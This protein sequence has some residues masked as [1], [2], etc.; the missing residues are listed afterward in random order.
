MT[1]PSAPALAPRK[2]TEGWV[3]P[4]TKDAPGD[5][6]QS[7]L[8]EIG[9]VA[10][11][12]DGDEKR[13]AREIE[14]GR[15]LQNIANQWA[16]DR[17]RQPTGREV[18]FGLL[19]QLRGQRRALRAVTEHLNINTHPLSK[20]VINKRLRLALDGEPDRLLIKHLTSSL[21]CNEPE[22][23]QCSVR[24]SVLTHILT[25]ELL[26]HA[27]QTSDG[28]KQP[29]QPRGQAAD[30]LGLRAHFDGLE[31]TG[32]RGQK[33]LTE[34]NLRLVVSI[35]RKYSR[36]GM[37]LSDLIQEGN[38][39]LMRAVDRFDYRRGYK[40]ST[41]GHWWIR[42]AITRA[43][44]DKARAIRM[45]VHMVETLRK[46]T[47]AQEKLVDELGREPSSEDIALE[48]DVSP[49]RVRQITQVSREPL[50]LEAP[51]GEDDAHIGD[52]VQDQAASTSD[53]AA[54]TLLRDEVR[55][56]LRNISDRERKVVELR[57][58]LADGRSRTLEEV[59]VVF[60]V[61]RERI[62]QIEATALRRLRHPSLAQKLRD[63]LD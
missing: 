62:R 9:K 12:S 6:V 14:E 43:I 45:P 27:A 33:E 63:Y 15:H 25:P 3:E 53:A 47:R 13:L 46:L 37:S 18:L 22:A 40:F 28:K 51:I 38:I 8:S 52:F 24:L 16:A 36:R 54:R 30:E 31:A 20:L 17:G 26:A 59:S 58:G 29:R 35:A 39:G 32:S 60:H 7:Y 61:T 56:V 48:M 11:L 57:F 42:Q 44:A 21:P 49:E 5:P 2:E 19:E 41:Y 23:E 50:S 10:L 55:D 4:D 1:N 34:A